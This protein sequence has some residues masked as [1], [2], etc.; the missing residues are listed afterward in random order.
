VRVRGSREDQERGLP[1]GRLA[2]ESR[3]S[4]LFCVDQDRGSSHVWQATAFLEF[5][6]L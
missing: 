1:E 3:G 6:Q 5:R 2:A 4:G